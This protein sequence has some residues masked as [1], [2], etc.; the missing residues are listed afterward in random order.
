MNRG[1][2]VKCA[3]NRCWVCE[4]P[5]RYIERW[6]GQPMHRHCLHI[7][8]RAFWMTTRIGANDFDSRLDNM[9]LYRFLRKIGKISK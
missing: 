8:D 9:K 5:T 1:D 4:R 2:F 3:W 7:A 6:Y